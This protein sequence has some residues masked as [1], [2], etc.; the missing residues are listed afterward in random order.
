MTW[1]H[2][3]ACKH[4]YWDASGQATNQVEIQ[5]HLPETWCLKMSW[6]YSHRRTWPCSPEGLGPGPVYR[7]GSTS[8]RTPR[9]SAASYLMTQSHQPASGIL[10]TRKDL[11]TNW[12][13]DIND[14]LPTVVSLPQQKYTCSPHREYPKA[15]SSD[16]QR[17]MCYWD[18]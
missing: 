11:E 1:A 17:G 7:W 9:S 18:T 8:P 4:Q 13:G 14:R 10:S 3:P 6:A 12:N 5:P 16:N 2:P 15:Y